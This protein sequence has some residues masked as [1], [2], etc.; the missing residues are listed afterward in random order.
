MKKSA[1]WLSR[2]M[3]LR[4]FWLDLACGA[5]KTIELHL[6]NAVALARAVEQAIAID[7]RDIASLIAD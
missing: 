1:L 2:A 6:G 4:S 7:D 5:E 3:T